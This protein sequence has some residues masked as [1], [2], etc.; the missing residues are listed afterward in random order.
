MLPGRPNRF[1]R[2][3]GWHGAPCLVLA[4]ILALG[5]SSDPEPRPDSRLGPVGELLGVDERI[6][7]DHLSAPVDLVRDRYGRLHIYASS[8]ADALR[9]QGYLVARDRHV[10]LDILRRLAQGRLAA[11]LGN[12]NPSLVEDD[13][14]MRH[15]GLGRVAQAQY[16]ELDGEA[17]ELVDAF[18]DGVTQL[19]RRIRSGEHLLPASIRNRPTPVVPL[20]AFTDWSGADSLAIGRLQIWLL[21][22]RAEADIERQALLDG[23]KE[24]FSIAAAEPSLQRRVGLERD[25]LRFAPPNPASVIEG[26][27]GIGETATPPRSAAA[28]PVGSSVTE[29]GRAEPRALAPAALARRYGPAASALAGTVGYRRAL[30]RVR[31]R[32]GRRSTAGSNG[33]VVAPLLSATGHALVANDP[34]LELTA[35]AIFWPV[36]I[37]VISPSGPDS[38][39]DLDVGGVAFPGIPGVILGH[40]RQVA[41]GATN[42]GYDVTDVYAET[43]TPAGDAVLFRGAPIPLETVEEIIEVRDG[44]S[45]TYDVQI[46]PHHGP[47]IPTI[48]DGQVKPADSQSGALSVRWT[49]F[50]PSFEIGAV[51][52]LMSARSVDEARETL[53]AWSAGAQSWMVAD[54]EGSILW[55]SHAVIPVRDDRA[56]TWDPATYEG[57]LPCLVLPGDGTAEWTGT[58]DSDGVPWAKNP[59][60]GYLA[61]ANNDPLGGTAD[62]DPSDD[63]QPDGRSGYLGCSFSMGYRQGRIRKLI[64]DANQPLSPEELAA[65]QGDIRSPLAAA[66]VPALLLAIANARQENLAP[67][68][69][70]P[71]SA[72]VNEPAYDDAAVAAVER[73]LV[74]W[75]D[76]SDFWATAGV[77]LATGLPLPTEA[78]PEAPEEEQAVAIQGRAAQAALLFN[79]WLVRLIPLAFGDELAQ[80]GLDRPSR[81]DL[82]ALLHL[83]ASEPES[84]AT[85]DE[86]TR[87]SALWDDLATPQLRE[88]RQERMIRALLAALGSLGNQVGPDLA[89]YRWGAQHTVRFD[90]VVPAFGGL[91]I[92][93]VADPVFPGGYPRHGD[94]YVVDA[95]SYSFRQRLDQDLDFSYSSGPVQRFVVDLD[96]AGPRAWN[97]LPGGAVWDDQSPHF[98]DEAELWRMNQVHPVP[99][100]LGE[101]A[102]ASGSRGVATPPR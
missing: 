65:I 16:A 4:L 46:V 14:A 97:A 94:G 44:G 100:A 22:Y 62:N 25:L 83:F 71:L 102:A 79:A 58:W 7:I 88:G 73:A 6:A 34:H 20:S 32:L 47:I 75:R 53:R 52:G 90:A 39:D 76:E 33:W 64:D 67:G 17:K 10:Q 30:D 8:R 63:R 50:E 70:P 54:V 89:A 49:G 82:R 2:R 1:A 37:H 66:L 93:P 18:A 68:S 35:P 11:L 99:F 40:N 42:A 45:V 9:V 26:F 77:D 43:L 84:L 27:A 59:L 55:T 3:R 72:V 69:H 5:C 87:D 31:A 95:S 51:L 23:M 91:S 98:S 29:P 56:L 96:P 85:Y 12:F 61:T 81:H 78:A 48:V 38:P 74:L 86:A 60:A 57:L 36:S 41:W 15:V 19:F 80:L 28:S 101:V 24:T 92:P 13:I 21:S